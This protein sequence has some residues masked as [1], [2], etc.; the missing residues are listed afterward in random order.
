MK[1]RFAEFAVSAA[2]SGIVPNWV[3]VGADFMSAELAAGRDGVLAL[4]QVVEAYNN[5]IRLNI[6]H[7]AEDRRIG[8]TQ[9]VE[10]TRAHAL[11]A[12]IGAAEAR[13]AYRCYAEMRR[14]PRKAT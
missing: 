8:A 6:A 10:V 13:G 7:L 12:L 1:T 4:Q 11:E 2:R 14:I 5:P 3:Q 9:Q